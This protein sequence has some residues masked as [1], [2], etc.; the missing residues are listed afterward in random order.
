MLH[1]AFD[2]RNAESE[3]LKLWNG[4][5]V[6]ANSSSAIYACNNT[7]FGDGLMFAVLLEEF[8][9]QRAGSRERR[10]ESREQRAESREQRAES[11]EQRAES[12]E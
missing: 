6:R 11:R 3:Y 1:V 9:E 2:R 12:R 4:A 5:K 10:A 8:R 7:R